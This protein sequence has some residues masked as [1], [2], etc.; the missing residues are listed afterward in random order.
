MLW[1]EE[2]V[3]I[4]LINFWSRGLGCQFLAES[5]WGMMTVFWIGDWKLSIFGNDIVVFYRIVLLHEMCRVVGT[6]EQHDAN[7]WGWSCL[8]RD[9]GVWVA[10]GCA[11]WLT[12]CSWMSE[13]RSELW[14]WY[15]TTWREG[16][17]QRAAEFE[18]ALVMWLRGIKN[19]TI[20]QIKRYDCQSHWWDDAHSPTQF[21]DSSVPPSCWV[22]RNCSEY[23]PGFH[24]PAAV[25]GKFWEL[26]GFQSLHCGP[27]LFVS[28]WLK[29]SSRTKSYKLLFLI[30]GLRN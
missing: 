28:R 17:I 1:D 7:T 16:V 26:A 15:G 19:L 29:V 24:K 22:C 3:I 20:T 6:M 18:W 9:C 30:L 21:W 10:S 25:I 5:G 4:L 8:S 23:S 12:R 2:V 11:E 13:V 14:L 27:C